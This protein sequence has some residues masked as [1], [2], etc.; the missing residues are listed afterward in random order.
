MIPRFASLAGRS[1]QTL[2]NMQQ[3]VT[4]S[5]LAEPK[6]II[7]ST[8]GEKKNVS[9]HVKNFNEDKS[10][11]A[12]VI[13]GSDKAFAAG[14]DIMEMMDKQF[15]DIYTGQFLSN[16]S[17]VAK[18]KKPVIAAVKGFCLGGGCEFAMMC[19]IIYAA[20]NA[21]FGQPEIKIGTIPGAGGTQRLT[22]AVGKSLA[23][24]MC[25]TGERI[26]AYEAQ[27]AG[28]VSKIFPTEKV[29]NEAIKLGER[30]ATQSPLIVQMAKEAVNSAYELSLKDGLQFERRL[31]HTTFATKD[32]KEGM[33]AFAEKRSPLWQ[34]E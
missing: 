12:I 11:G 4:L 21:H 14:A 16:W 9:A 25:L 32:R 10:I 6:M 5:T 33:T 17:E 8:V 15:A 13:T 1:C 30:I 34:S 26:N 20:E 19:D 24:E 29:V 27:Q 22:R 2:R 23:M 3:I 7:V 18:S 31:F 28:L